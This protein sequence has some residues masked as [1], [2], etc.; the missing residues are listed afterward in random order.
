MWKHLRECIQLKPV[1]A[2]PQSL[3]FFQIITTKVT[4]NKTLYSSILSTPTLQS[5]RPLQTCEKYRAHNHTEHSNTKSF[6]I[7]MIPLA[8]DLISC[9]CRLGFPA[10]SESNHLCR[11]NTFHAHN[12]S[13]LTHEAFDH[14]QDYINKIHLSTSILRIC[15]YYAKYSHHT[16]IIDNINKIKTII[17][18]QQ[19]ASN[20][21]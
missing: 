1:C 14:L 21:S 16:Y 6:I 11:W 13:S 17:H 9:A 10:H 12:T 2:T 18:I 3:L 15:E 4:W 5:V 7:V 8:G 20:I 19:Y